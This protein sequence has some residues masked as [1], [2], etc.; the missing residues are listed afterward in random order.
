MINRGTRNFTENAPC[1][2]KKNRQSSFDSIKPRR[3]L[4][5]KNGCTS[6]AKPSLIATPTQFK[7]YLPSRRRRHYNCSAKRA[8]P[9]GPRNGRAHFSLS[10]SRPAQCETLKM[11][12]FKMTCRRGVHQIPSQSPRNFFPRLSSSSFSFPAGER[13]GTG[14]E[15]RY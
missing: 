2:S 12:V 13:A 11:T 4:N 9:P 14:V 10:L 8:R 1:E 5:H 6:V 15:T 3:N 7:L